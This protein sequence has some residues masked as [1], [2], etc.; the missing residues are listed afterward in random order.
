MRLRLAICLG[1]VAAV[2][3]V[4]P[5]PSPVVAA[6][7]NDTTC[8]TAVNGTPAGS[9]GQ[10][11]TGYVL[12]VGGASEFGTVW[13]PSTNTQAAFPSVAGY[14]T[15]DS[16]GRPTRQ[17]AVSFST[18]KDV[19][20]DNTPS[21]RVMSPDG[22]YTFPASSY[23]QAPPPGTVTRLR[24]GTFFGVGF[25]PVAATATTATFTTY[26]ST[27][28]G[29]TWTTGT[30]LFD[31]G[32]TLR[33]A[34]ADGG[35]RTHSFPVELA[36]GTILVSI[37]GTYTDHPTGVN[38]S[39]VQAS[40][41]GGSTFI[42]RGVIANPDTTNSYPEAAIGQLPNGNLLSVVRHHVSGNLATPVWTTS[43]NGGTT[44]A[45]LQTLSVSWPYGYD[46][47]DDTT[48]ALL[49]VAPALRLMPNG[50][51][52][53]S[54]G[55]PDNW[56]AISSNGQGTGW[57]GQLTYRN[58]P[59]TGSRVHGS[60]GNTG[61]ASVASNRAIQVGDNCEL[62]WSCTNTSET[63]F[64]VD[65]QTRIWR[66]F[67]D[68]L[69]PDVGKID[70]AGKYRL[71]QVTVD[72]NMTWTDPAHPRARVDGALD[73]STEYW[74][75][76]VRS[77][78]PGSYVLTLDHPYDLTRI[79]LS[80]RNG[81]LASG[82]VYASTD[83]VNWGTPIVDAANRTH[84]ALEYF[85]LATPT[86]ARYVKVEVDA[87]TTCDDAQTTQCAFLNE[88]E[89]YS[90]I[91]S[92][93]N[94]PMNNRPRGYTGQVLS[95]V[96]WENGPGSNRALRV[97]DNDPNAQARVDWIGTAGTSRVLDFRVK[98]AAMPSALLFDVL[99]RNS[100]GTTV[101]AFHLAVFSDGSLA[102]HDGSNWY[103]MTAPGLVPVGQWTTLR[104]EATTTSATL[105][106]NGTVRASLIA[107]TTTTSTLVGHT[108]ASGGTKP[109]GDDFL[110][111]D[112]LSR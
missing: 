94:D 6:S 37:Y 22:G 13:D 1:V 58:C 80:L 105:Y 66:R 43:T 88:L 93:E 98:P 111:D 10:S 40:T 4:T 7:S 53:L 33:T 14:D 75:S 102:R 24:N 72:T 73:G 112:V 45:A 52:L 36:D 79:G 30:A 49:G 95:W 11:P 5:H 18:G 69:T 99:G 68:V 44:W 92:F 50:V 3:V 65:K 61:I 84:Y 15:V 76:A 59:T 107:P 32:A 35:P 91:D 39:Q 109:T 23:T 74:S 9:D 90:R 81:R 20:G 67:V 51:V 28:D 104:V 26:R 25:K 27:D 70:L 96:T 71:G 97:V 48:K 56:V 17:L 34:T 12:N 16:A 2:V 8:A 54:S 19:P 108:F 29:A 47:Y 89:L 31:L 64:T 77:G 60:T 21:T 62:T 85:P 57:V 78:G 63:G 83:G 55:R 106:V 87:S 100:A 101:P 86:P 110:I 42:R 103:V 41:D 82:R 38:R 46:P